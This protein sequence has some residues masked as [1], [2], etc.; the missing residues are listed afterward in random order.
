MKRSLFLITAL[1]FGLYGFTWA[2]P[3]VAV[4]PS[5][6]VPPAVAVPH[7]RASLPVPV[8]PAPSGL[9]VL[10][11][12]ANGLLLEYTPGAVVR[13]RLGGG[14]MEALNLSDCSTIRDIGKPQVPIRSV[15]FGV[16]FGATVQAQVLSSD[17]VDIGEIDLA[18]VP[19]GTGFGPTT[20]VRDP[21][22]YGTNALFPPAVM[23]L[24]TP[25]QIRSQ[26][27]ARLSLYP[28]QYNPVTKRAYQCRKMTIQVSFSVPKGVPQVATPDGFDDVFKTA[29]VNFEQ[30]K[31]W[32]KPPTPPRIQSFIFDTGPWYK[33]KV[34]SNGLYKVSG[35]DLQ[36]AGVDISQIDP[37]TLKLY[38][39]GGKLLNR[40]HDAPLPDTMRQVAVWVVGE[41][42]TTLQSGDYFVFY[43]KGP[44]GPH[45]DDSLDTFLYYNP[46]TDTNVYWLTWGGSQGL[47]M[48][49]KD[50]SLSD[51]NPIRPSDFMCRVHVEQDNLNIYGEGLR[52]YW[53]ELNS[54]DNTQ[55]AH[56]QVNLAGVQTQEPCSLWV[57]IA[58]T[59]PCKDLPNCDIPWDR[60]VNIWFNN[61]QAWSGHI[62][63]RDPQPYPQGSRL[64]VPAYG[65]W[66][67]E[68][69]NTLQVQRTGDPLS[70][71]WFE[72]V[73]RRRYEAQ[74]DTLEFSTY[75]NLGT[76]RYEFSVANFTD[77]NIEVFDI[78]DPFAPARIT[79][80]ALQ[81]GTLKF[82]DNVDTVR[83]Y[84]ASPASAY[85][86]PAGI[87]SKPYSNLHDPNNAADYIIITN[88][89]FY[90]Q[91][92]A[93]RNLRSSKGHT[94]LMVRLSNV[95][96]EFSWGL[97]DPTA[98]RNFLHYAYD[99]WDHGRGT[100]A[101][102]LL[103]GDGN[104][105]FKNLLHRSHPTSLFP[106][107][108]S[109]AYQDLGGLGIEDTMTDDW[110]AYFTQDIYP[111][112]KLGRLPVQT[113]A[114]A[115]V[116]IDKILNY[117]SPETYGAWRN[118][119]VFVAD[120]EYRLC[121][122]DDGYWLKH[123]EQTELIATQHFTRQFDFT[124]VYL[125][126]YARD[127]FCK[128]PG[129][130]ADVV[131]AISNGAVFVS[132]V[133]HGGWWI[134]A[135]EQA[136]LSPPDVSLLNNGKKLPIICSASCS[137]G[138]F[139]M[140]DNECMAELEVRAKD[141]GAI[142][143]VAATGGTYGGGPNEDMVKAF[144][145][146]AFTDSTDIGTGLF[147]AK[148]TLK[149]PGNNQLILLLGDPGLV[150]AQ[151]RLPLSLSVSDTIGLEGKRLV[152]VHGTVGGGFNGT[153]LVTAFDSDSLKT[154]NS[155][156]GM[157]TQYRL[158]GNPIFTGP[159]K[160]TNGQFSASFFVPTG[161]RSGKSGRVSAYV[162]ND[163]VD[164][165]GALDSIP[166][167]GFDDTTARDDGKGPNITLYANGKQ[168]LNGDRVAPSF[169]LVGVLEDDHGINLSNQQ[170]LPYQLRLVINNDRLNAH[171]I[172]NDFAYDLGS[173][174]KGSFS[175]PVT[176]YAPSEGDSTYTLTIEAADN[177]L[178]RSS[179]SVRVVVGS[180]LSLAVTNLVNYPNPFKNDTQFTF[181][182][183]QAAEA[184]I[185]IYT[186]AGRLI[187][188]L[189]PGLLPAGYN[190]V[191]WDGRDADGDRLANGV[192]L[193]KISAQAANPGA[194][195]TTSEISA[196]EYGKLV[197]MR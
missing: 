58:G 167:R 153:A 197:V 123:T 75:G 85:K 132:F 6:A 88:D 146:K 33:I 171:Y 121:N 192:Y 14:S 101:Y 164:G 185:K 16:P 152:Q 36:K 119:A 39:G 27:I 122:P 81:G 145:D 100:A 94:V 68:G 169:T 139:D 74:N 37:Y 35:S 92:Q 168:L 107:Y 149:N 46:Y 129:A 54:G 181:E 182:L 18:P 83:A 158:P 3:P 31:A 136:F 126:E 62:S 19:R 67:V 97:A 48:G 78:T 143:T 8:S 189:R 50:G 70:F 63:G 108:T 190:Q 55:T 140:T 87:T 125:T 131:K 106:I 61:N 40:N 11:S 124:K 180:S 5:V 17:L 151:P 13:S 144:V 53:E 161:L 178:N 26:R 120:D 177:F 4:P 172:A 196:K 60:D 76:G 80:P 59:G 47:R 30:A 45:Y 193:Y 184:E 44:Y 188:T 82:Q 84:V 112:M 138:K 7:A 116:V 42:H 57:S 115:S 134:W 104:S 150:P 194:S 174:T 113:P 98:V 25:F 23:S 71:D 130:E 29:L 72:V 34:L 99:N 93:I 77:P 89:L 103:V 56:Y 20:W 24:H 12:D 64:L 95:Y 154:Y 175:A 156:L 22:T 9:R 127:P 38:N 135:H 165:H 141:K 159:V 155:P 32:R 15:L 133:G 105:D 142:A 49:V 90:D 176:L 1:L 2:G 157:S 111:E 186:V 166:V 21:G 128:K 96:D 41:D 118:R 163:Q 137:V 160:V 173:Y 10:R 102:A 170:P 195:G 110:F 183:T 117:D 65:P 79:T 109:A 86:T 28:V 187:R 191:Y 51:P 162:W 147:Y 91:M 52:W 69:D 66:A 148:F 179:D 43:G 73:Y 114:D